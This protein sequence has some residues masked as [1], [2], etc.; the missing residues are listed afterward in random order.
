VSLHFQWLAS[1]ALTSRESESDR[2]SAEG[3]ISEQQRLFPASAES[4]PELPWLQLFDRLSLRLCCDEPPSP[5]PIDLPGSGQLRLRFSQRGEPVFDPYPFSKNTL[6]F[7][8]TGRRVP[9]RKYEN[10]SDFQ[11][12]LDEAPVVEVC[13]GVARSQH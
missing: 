4:T 3:F 12:D 2:P 7:A 10:D 13:W 11:S 1:Q 8:T 9:I 5:G 6:Q